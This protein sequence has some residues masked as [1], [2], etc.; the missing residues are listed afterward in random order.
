[1]LKDWASKN[2]I[3]T[4]TSTLWA[5]STAIWRDGHEG[6]PIFATLDIETDEMFLKDWADKIFKELAAELEKFFNT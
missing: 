6:R 3:P 4:D 2:G 1:V 5:I